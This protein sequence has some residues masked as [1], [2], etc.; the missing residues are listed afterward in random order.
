MDDIQRLELEK[1]FEIL[2][3]EGGCTFIIYSPD[4]RQMAEGRL[5]DVQTTIETIE[6]TCKD[7]NGEA[8]STSKS[9]STKIEGYITD[10]RL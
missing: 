1:A 4:G 7:D 3:T 8:A 2:T 5:I 9:V 6:A 10:Y